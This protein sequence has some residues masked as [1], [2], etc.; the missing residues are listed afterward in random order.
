MEQQ[1]QSVRS[2]GNAFENS[3]KGAAAATRGATEFATA[4]FLGA[5]AITAQVTATGAQ[6]LAAHR[7]GVTYE[8]RTALDFTAQRFGKPP[9]YFD[10]AVKS[11][12]GVDQ[13]S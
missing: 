4:M 2:V 6:W 10:S 9:D 11:A 3:L 1:S 13:L 5:K 8:D 7:S 12:G